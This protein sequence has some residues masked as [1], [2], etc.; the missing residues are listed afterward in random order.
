MG[1]LSFT[2][3]QDTSRGHF[4]HLTDRDPLQGYHCAPQ[5]FYFRPQKKWYLIYQSGQPQYSTNP[6]INN[7]DGWTA[8]VDFFD[9]VPKS[10]VDKAWLDYWI[11]ADDSFVY[12]FFTNDNGSFYRSRTA[13]KDFPHKMSDPVVAMKDSKE[14]LF[15]GSAT[16]RLKGLDKYLTLVEAMG[17]AR[18]YRAF[19][20]DTLDGQWTELAGSWQMP[21]AG[22]AN[23]E[24]EKGVKPWTKDISHGELLREGYD[25][26]MLVDPKNL[27]LLFQGRDPASDGMDYQKLP[28][29]LGLLTLQKGPW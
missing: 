15:E 7:P 22:M 19:L 10:V 3:W 25:E 2:N 1:H 17:P 11:I 29:K 5:V 24:F 8:P 14:A 26:R 27:R 16:Y 20:A 12:L 13:I 18:Y 9:G 23:V 4:T 28:Y 6:D 21:F